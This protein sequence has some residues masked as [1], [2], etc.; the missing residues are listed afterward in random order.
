MGY[1]GFVLQSYR[2]RRPVDFLGIAAL[3][4]VIAKCF[5]SAEGLVAFDAYFYVACVYMAPR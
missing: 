1:V 5:V 4:N 2:N 3:K